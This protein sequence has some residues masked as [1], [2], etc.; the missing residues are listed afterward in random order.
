MKSP[1]ARKRDK[2]SPLPQAGLCNWSNRFAA[3]LTLLA[4]LP[5]SAVVTTRS[6]SL[7]SGIMRPKI[8]KSEARIAGL[9]NI[10]VMPIG[11]NDRLIG[12]ATDRDIVCKG[13]RKVPSIRSAQQRARRDDPCIHCCPE[14]DDNG[15]DRFPRAVP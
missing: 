8:Q 10:G 5:S 7:S 4:K 11:E 3:G 12:I 6:G 2:N 9:H 13:L 1:G 15:G 14:E